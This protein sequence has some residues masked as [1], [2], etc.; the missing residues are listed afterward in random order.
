MYAAMRKF[1][2][3]KKWINV[4][5]NEV[6]ISPQKISK[7]KSLLSFKV[8]KLPKPENDSERKIIPTKKTNN[9]RII[10]KH[11]SNFFYKFFLKSLM[12]LSR[13]SLKFILLDHP[14]FF[15]KE[16]SNFFLLTPSSF[17]LLLNLIKTDG[18]ILFFILMA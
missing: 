11:F 9:S 2:L 10:I 15:A 17:F 18:S 7:K 6:I 4:T 13:A 1:I 12:V 3:E 5:I 16:T 8:N 14:F